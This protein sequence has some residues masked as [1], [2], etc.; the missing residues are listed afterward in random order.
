MKKKNIDSRGSIMHGRTD[1][2]PIGNSP[3]ESTFFFV[4]NCLH[5]LLND[6]VHWFESFA[7][8]LIVVMVHAEF[9]D[10]FLVSDQVDSFALIA[11]S[12]FADPNVTL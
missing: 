10:F 12:R 4:L 7:R 9:L 1:Q 8:L 3:A 2:G 6:S 11:P 5:S